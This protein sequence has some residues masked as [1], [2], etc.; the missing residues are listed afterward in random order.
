MSSEYPYLFSPPAGPISSVL[1]PFHIGDVIEA[2]GELRKTM[3]RVTPVEFARDE[4]AY[5]ITFL[6]PDNLWKPFV[7]SFGIPL[8]DPPD[9]YI[10]HRIYR[11]RGLVG[12][13][14]PNN[15]SLLGPLLMVL[16]SLTG[17]RLHLK[18]G[19]R[20]EN[21][22]QVFR[23]FALAYLPPGAL[24]EHLER[25]VLVLTFARD[26]LG[27]R[28]LA[29]SAAARIVF[30]S[31]QAAAQIHA[32]AGGKPSLGF[33]FVDRQS[34]VWV[35]P[36]ALCDD[37]LSSIVKVFSIYGRAGCT[38][39][40]RIVIIDGNQQMAHSVRQRIFELWSRV[41]RTTPEAHVAS[42]NVLAKQWGAV[43]G[44]DTIGAPNYA[45]VLAC[46]DPNTP[47]P[48]GNLFLPVVCETLESA[49]RALPSN[50]QTIGV[51]APEEELENRWMPILGPVVSRVVPIAS[52]HHFG[53][54]WDGEEYWRS[55]FTCCVRESTHAYLRS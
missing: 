46:G 53:E 2:W 27:N 25:Q 20:S 15:V 44:W 14:L 51:A 29:E 34:Q 23:D 40:Q 19:S 7:S 50:I 5:L 30:G 21:L 55:C 3:L 18:A 47:L 17:N 31:D 16:L 11:G 9:R 45:A 24:R 26:E 36:G 43:L 28:Q 39:P 22:V 35:S 33:S 1:L 37:V 54:I 38:S 52:M 41:L 4:W 13:W 8:P 10:A 6:D 42:A 12:V 48:D 49:V 32:L